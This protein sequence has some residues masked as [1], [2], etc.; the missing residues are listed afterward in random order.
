MSAGGSSVHDANDE[1]AERD[2]GGEAEQVEADV[3]PD[4]VV[5]ERAEIHRAVAEARVH[6]RLAGKRPVGGVDPQDVRSEGEGQQSEERGPA[7]AHE[8]ERDAGGQEREED[9]E[10]GWRCAVADEPGTGDDVESDGDGDRRRDR[11]ERVVQGRPRRRAQDSS[12][13]S[14]MAG[15]GTARGPGSGPRRRRPRRGG[16]RAGS[17]PV[18][19][20]ATPPRAT[21]AAA[22]KTASPAAATTGRTRR[23]R[24]REP[25]RCS[26]GRVGPAARRSPIRGV[27]EPAPGVAPRLMALIARPG[28]WWLRPNLPMRLTFGSGF[29]DQTVM[30]NGASRRTSAPTPRRRR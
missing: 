1:P 25:A 17:P 24:T 22:A 11:H 30:P 7:V 26:R 18:R 20:G 6:H 12:A 15:T 14:A 13:P 28:T 9:E 3:G 5:E 2:D 10:P 19:R 29:G 16:R 27:A 8:Q 4:D 21:S 23:P